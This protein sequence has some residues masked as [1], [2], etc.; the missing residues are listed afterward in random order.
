MTEQ[1]APT[2][3]TEA[4]EVLNTR[5]ADKDWGGRV[6]NGDVAANKELRDLTAMVAAGGAD[7]VAV[8][9][10]GNPANIPTTDQAQMAHTAGLFRELGIRDEVTRE[11]LEGKKVTPLEYELVANW[12]KIQMGDADFVKRFLDGGVKERQLMMIADT[13]I[14]NGI[15]DQS[16]AS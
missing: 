13:V 3:A 4:R 12:K 14:V 11:F 6:F 2:N 9:M 10:N 7:T 5:M 16:G 1:A 15:K 8:A